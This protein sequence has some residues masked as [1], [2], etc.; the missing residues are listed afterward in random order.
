[1]SPGAS[2]GRMGIC[3]GWWQLCGC[4]RVKEG[5]WPGDQGAAKGLVVAGMSG[6]RADPVP[7]RAGAVVS[8]WGYAT[9][10]SSLQHWWS[11]PSSLM[12]QHA[13]WSLT[14]GRFA[15]GNNGGWGG[16]PLQDLAG[17]L[18]QAVS[19]AVCPSL[20]VAIEGSS[21]FELCWHRGSVSWPLA[22][23]SRRLIG[24]PYRQS[25][26]LF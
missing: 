15:R 17:P 2:S 18:S 24:V 5:S 25:G 4:D 11:P 1:M 14:K 8:Q 9:H 16:W 21:S 6:F 13:M 22:G 7:W 23:D 10:M 20:F 19:M 3:E 12:L 26:F